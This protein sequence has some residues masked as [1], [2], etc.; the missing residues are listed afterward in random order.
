[1]LRPLRRFTF[2]VVLTGVVSSLSVCTGQTLAGGSTSN[3]SGNAA[4]QRIT[5]GDQVAVSVLR[6]PELSAKC[7]VRSD[8]KITLPMVD[9][10]FVSGLNAQELQ[11]LLTGKLKSFLTSP[12]VSVIVQARKSALVSPSGPHLKPG[13]GPWLLPDLWPRS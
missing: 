3:K 11:D 1:M 10:V 12:Q 13:R 5:V 4:S 8:G 9:E 2:A 6:E 7:I